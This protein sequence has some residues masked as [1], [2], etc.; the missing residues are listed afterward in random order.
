MVRKYLDLGIFTTRWIDVFYEF[1]IGLKAR[2]LFFSFFFSK[3]FITEEFSIGN[4]LSSSERN[5]DAK[6][7]E[8][9]FSND[10]H[11]RS[12]FTKTLLHQ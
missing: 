1:L 12:V 2:K 8:E 6:W 11:L 4:F 7:C 5:L 9:I 3:V 10:A